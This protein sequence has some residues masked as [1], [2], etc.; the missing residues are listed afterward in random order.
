MRR[1]CG[2]VYATEDGA[3]LVFQRDGTQH[4]LRL[5]Y[6]LAQ[7]RAVRLIGTG[8][9]YGDL[10]RVEVTGGG[11]GSKGAPRVKVTPSKQ[12]PL[13]KKCIRGARHVLREA[14]GRYLSRFPPATARLLDL[15]SVKNLW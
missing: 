15:S 2:H 3:D 5:R 1:P 12:A 11:K 13:I 9:L 4:T 10:T 6:V 8:V 7:Q 14:L